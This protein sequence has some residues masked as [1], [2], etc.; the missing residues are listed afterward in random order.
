MSEHGGEVQGESKVVL[1]ELESSPCNC[2]ARL[3][4]ACPKNHSVRQEQPM[5]MDSSG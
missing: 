3:C 2:F 1:F 5:Q 4:V